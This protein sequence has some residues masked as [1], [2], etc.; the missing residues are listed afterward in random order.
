MRTITKYGREKYGQQ[1]QRLVL[2]ISK[3]YYIWQWAGDNKNQTF[4]KSKVYRI[5]KDIMK[6][7]KDP[8]N[9]TNRNIFLVEDVLTNDRIIPVIYQA[10]ID[11]WK[12]FVRQVHCHKLDEHEYEVTMLFENEQLRKHNKL[13][14][15]YKIF[16]RLR[17]ERV[18][19]IEGFRIMLDKGK[20]TKLQF[21]EIFKVNIILKMMISMAINL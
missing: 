21:K 7:L 6:S 2:R 15:F 18:A 11:S 16:R 19:D 12:N 13:Y 3:D 1:K 20:P 5:Y 4:E 8:I 17:Y 14:I 10:A 9:S